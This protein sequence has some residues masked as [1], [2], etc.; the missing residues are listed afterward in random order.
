MLICYHGYRSMSSY[1]AY[2]YNTGKGG[3]DGGG[4]RD[5]PTSLRPTTASRAG[6]RRRSITPPDGERRP[7]YYQEVER[8]RNPGSHDERSH[9]SYM[10]RPKTAYNSNAPSAAAPS[11]QDLSV[12]QA[13]R[14]RADSPDLSIVSDI[15][16]P[17]I[18]PN[19]STV[20]YYTYTKCLERLVH[21]ST[22]RS[23]QMIYYTLIQ[24][25]Y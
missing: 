5:S 15:S 9:A 21:H 14:A 16:E 3:S 17:Q 18:S 22:L 24:C 23:F 2:Y 4:R 13:E 10:E 20:D 25:E 12:Q 8:P 1:G 11:Q 19:Y 6:A 7:P